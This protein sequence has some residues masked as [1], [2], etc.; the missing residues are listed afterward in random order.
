MIDGSFIGGSGLRDLE[1]LGILGFLVVWIGMALWRVWTQGTKGS[2][3]QST[4]SKG[5]A[6]K[7][8][9]YQALARE[10]AAKKSGKA[11][12][13]GVVEAAVSHQTEEDESCQQ[14]KTL[15]TPY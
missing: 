7:K 4:R 6:A 2:D 1:Q 12:W 9:Y 11:W 5:N 8:G 3:P 15:Q 13:S 14:P 10:K